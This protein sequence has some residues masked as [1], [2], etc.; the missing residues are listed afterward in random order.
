M[1]KE[2]EEQAEINPSQENKQK[3]FEE[4]KYNKLIDKM[5]FLDDKLDKNEAK[6]KAFKDRIQQNIKENDKKNL[7]FRN[8]LIFFDENNLF[9][10]INE[11][12][13]EFYMEQIFIIIFS[14][15]S[16]LKKRFVE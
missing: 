11:L 2:I 8:V 13:D 12:I 14:S 1:V 5:I 3:P 6:I 10:T 7:K 9:D 15:D 4:K 16:D